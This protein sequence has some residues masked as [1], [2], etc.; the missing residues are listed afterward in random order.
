MSSMKT[1][2]SEEHLLSR[3]FTSTAVDALLL[4]MQPVLPTPPPADREEGK[5]R[6]G[7]DEHALGV[8]DLKLIP[9][10]AVNPERD[11]LLSFEG[12][13]GGRTGFRLAV[14]LEDGPARPLFNLIRKLPGHGLLP[15]KLSED[16]QSLEADP[17]AGDVQLTGSRLFLV[18]EGKAGGSVA[19][20][21]SPNREPPDDVV[22]LQLQPPTVLIG[23]TGFGLHF[24]HGLVLDLA[25]NATPADRVV[26]DGMTLNTPADAPAWQGI[27][28]NR[29]RF[30]LPEGVPFIG[31]HPV[32]AWLQV[33]LPPTAGIDLI[34]QAQVPPDGDRP[35]IDVRIECRDPSATGLDGFVPTLVEAV[36]ELPLKDRTESFGQ[37]ITSA[38]ASRC[39]RGCATA[40]SR[41]RPVWRRAPK[42]AWRSKARAVKAC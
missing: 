14:A 33:G 5:L 13:D 30:F 22:V 16:K 36:M 18:L 21:L 3:I 8:F 23:G 41:R 29:A 10:P 27:A 31:N 42:S 28:V 37:P 34:V 1:R 26:V 25:D 4:A 35:A 2:L 7:V 11:Y 9:P 39:G 24:T 40:A 32:D 19:L 12:P 20:R 17:A 15:A 6:F 38:P